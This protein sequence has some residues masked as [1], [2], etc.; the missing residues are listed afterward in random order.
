MSP[1]LGSGSLSRESSSVVVVTVATSLPTSLLRFLKIRCRGDV[2][3]DILA[4]WLAHDKVQFE[5][6][7]CLTQVKIDLSALSPADGLFAS[8][9]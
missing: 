8:G 6:L 9:A 4:I 1:S 3:I 2:A 5:S 7:P